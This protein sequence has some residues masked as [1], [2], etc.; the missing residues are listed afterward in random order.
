MLDIKLIRDS[1]DIV[2]KNLKRRNNTENIKMLNEVILLDK[3]WREKLEETTKLR[4]ERNKISMEI[5]KQKK[6]GKNIDNLM[7]QAIKIPKELDILEKETKKIQENVKNILMKLPNLLHDSVPDGKDESQNKEIKII[8]KKPEFDFKPKDHFE[9]LKD[10]NMI[11]SESGAKAAGHAFFYLK[12]DIVLL[13]I[14]LQKFALDYLLKKNFTIVEPP[15]MLN[16]DSIMG[17]IDMDD[18][19]EQIYKINGEDLF[20]IGTSEHSIV[21]MMKDKNLTIDELPIMF[22][23]ISPCFR[24]EV[25]SHGKYTKGLFRMHQFNK[26]E[27]FIFCKPENSYEWFEKLQQNTEEIY[28]NLGLYYRVMELCTGDIGVKAAKSIDIECWMADN[29]FREV[30]SNSNVTD[31]QSR[32]LNIKYKEKQGQKSIGFLHTLNNTSIATSRIM[33]AI[34]EQNQQKD[35]SVKIPNKLIPYMNGIKYLKKN[36]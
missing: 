3:K 16:S 19:K 6:E 18:F 7:K 30:S 33:V 23:G 10:L 4:F 25:G 24:K 12:G 32:R 22:A 13:D 28:N 34:L 36:N 21:A 14:A 27:Q 5:S 11:D 8:G 20:L 1:L 15:L 2:E 29:T 35:G 26:I 17:A 31:Y 9:I